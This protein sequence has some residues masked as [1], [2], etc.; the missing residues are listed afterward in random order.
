MIFRGVQQWLAGLESSQ[1][2]AWFDLRWCGNGAG[3]VVAV[4]GGGVAALWRWRVCGLRFRIKIF[5]PPPHPRDRRRLSAWPHEFQRP[6]VSLNLPGPAKLGNPSAQRPQPP[7]PRA[8]ARARTVDPQPPITAC[9]PAVQRQR[10]R[11][12]PLSPSLSRLRSDL[13]SPGMARTWPPGGVGI[14][15]VCGLQLQ[16]LMH[17]TR[18]NTGA[19]GATHPAPGCC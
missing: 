17:L 6:L 11:L 2:V 5:P 18:P 16:I 10:V 15:C 8:V 9:F 3:T 13:T 4:G 7:A 1:E 14:F 12:R 19:Q